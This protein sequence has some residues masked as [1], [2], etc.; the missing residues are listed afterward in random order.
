MHWACRIVMET[1]ITAKPGP[2]RAP[3][4]DVECDSRGVARDGGLLPRWPLL[5]LWLLPVRD[6]P[7]TPVEMPFEAIAVDGFEDFDLNN[8]FE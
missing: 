2:W 3:K 8:S 5:L 6:T 1:I 7:T 4:D